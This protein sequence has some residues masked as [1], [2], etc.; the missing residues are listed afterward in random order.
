MGCLLASPQRMSRDVAGWLCIRKSGVPGMGVD[1]QRVCPCRYRATETSSRQPQIYNA[2]MSGQPTL[3]SQVRLPFLRSPV[4]SRSAPAY[5]PLLFALSSALF[6]GRFLSR[7]AVRRSDAGCVRARAVPGGAAI[8]AAIRLDGAAA[9]AAAAA[10]ASGG[11]APL[12][13]SPSGT[14]GAGPGAT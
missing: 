11:P 13:V 1:S 6:A 3:A 2:A 4:S 12:H 5:A 8:P 9:A 14:A 10:A 7:C